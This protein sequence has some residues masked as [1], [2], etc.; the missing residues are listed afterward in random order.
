MALPN[1]DKNI[2]NYFLNNIVYLCLGRHEII[3][4]KYSVLILKSVLGNSKIVPMI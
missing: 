1:A 2:H 3:K 4:T